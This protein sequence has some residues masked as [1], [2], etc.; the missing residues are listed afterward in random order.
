MPAAFAGTLVGFV[1]LHT[2]EPSVTVAFLLAGGLL[3]GFAGR[4]LF[5]LC[6][7]IVGGSV[8]ASYGVATLLHV[9]PRAWPQPEVGFTYVT[10]GAFAIVVAMLA[11]AAGAAL[12]RAATAR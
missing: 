10:V 4:R 8:P 3:A 6:A 2:T 11:S 9:T 1:E 5:W 7:V 12:A